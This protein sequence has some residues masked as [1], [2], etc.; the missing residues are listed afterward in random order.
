[1]PAPQAAAKRAVP[2]CP[3]PIQMSFISFSFLAAL[4]EIALQRGIT[5]LTAGFCTI[6]L[7]CGWIWFA[8]IL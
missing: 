3:P 4:L 7:T 2:H 8:G 6:L 5:L 1:M